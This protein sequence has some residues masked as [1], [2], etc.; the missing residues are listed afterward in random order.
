MERKEEIEKE[1]LEEDTVEKQDTTDEDELKDEKPEGAQEKDHEVQELTN[2]LLRLQAD[3]I[4]F[5]NRVEK[6]KEKIYTYAAEEIV[7]QLL[8]VLDNFERALESVEEE[9]SFYQGVKMIYDQILKV[10]NGNGLKEIKCLGERFDPN[11]HHAVFA[12]EVE[13]KEEGTI[14]EVLQKGYLLNDKVIRPSMVKVAK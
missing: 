7:T 12:E 1:K 8:P 4:N 9:D 2:Q 14:L 10:L 6:D 13:D 11:F 3:F 5:K